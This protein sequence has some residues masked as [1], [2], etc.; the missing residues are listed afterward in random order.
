[1]GD[2]FLRCEYCGGTYSAE[3]EWCPHCMAPRPEREVMEARADDT[4]VTVFYSDNLAYSQISS[5]MDD[6]I[7][8]NIRID[9]DGYVTT[10]THTNIVDE[11]M[12]LLGQMGTYFARVL[13]VIIVIE[14]IAYFIMPML[15]PTSTQ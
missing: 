1:M 6:E 10:Q 5:G 9:E 3:R 11:E 4:D 8:W 7:K 14:I 15:F 2:G 13:M 12:E